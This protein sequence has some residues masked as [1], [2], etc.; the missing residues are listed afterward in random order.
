MKKKERLSQRKPNKVMFSSDIKLYSKNAKKH[1]DQQLKLIA[2]SL[3]E[4]GW[5][6]PIV[7]D[8]NNT[9]IVGHGLRMD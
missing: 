6:Q 9:I 2:R 8:K 5:R 3:K 7:V 1:P 4:Y